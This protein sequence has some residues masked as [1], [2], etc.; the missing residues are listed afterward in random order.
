MMG[1]DCDLWL[2]GESTTVTPS[3]ADPSSEEDVTAH[4]LRGIVSTVADFQGLVLKNLTDECGPSSCSRFRSWQREQDGGE[5]Q[6]R[7]YTYISSCV[8]ASRTLYWGINL[9][10][11]GVRPQLL[12]CEV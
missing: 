6:E 4:C 7:R 2:V 5:L 3:S 1:D 11:R 8:K 10:K 9:A 12:G